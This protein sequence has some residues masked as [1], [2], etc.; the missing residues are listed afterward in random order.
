MLIR[1]LLFIFV[2]SFGLIDNAYAGQKI[3]VGKFISM[4]DSDY[5]NETLWKLR[6]NNYMLIAR[7]R[8]TNDFML[9]CSSEIDR[10]PN[11]ARE[12]CDIFNQEAPDTESAI[13]AALTFTKLMI[14]SLEK[15]P[16]TEEN[17]GHLTYL[18]G[19][20]SEMESLPMPAHEMIEKL[21]SKK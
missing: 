19:Q 15:E 5:F 13:L 1:V 8:S 2:L 3:D 11:N 10:K 21:K 12:P 9:W 4:K 16:S 17:I 6:I 20:L 7:L 18:K 14:K